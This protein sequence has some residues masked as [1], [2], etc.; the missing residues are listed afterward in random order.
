MIGRSD[1][2][3]VFGG[4]GAIFL[5]AILIRSLLNPS[6]GYL[7]GSFFGLCFGTILCWILQYRW[8]PA[9]LQMKKTNQSS[10]L[11]TSLLIIVAVLSLLVS[12]MLNF[13]IPVTLQDVFLSSLALTLT[14]FSWYIA[15]QLWRYRPRS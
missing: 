14:V 5:V 11:R 12:R 10:T 13:L 8:D 6:I 2:I 1:S 3:W 7:V 4:L 15:I 9:H